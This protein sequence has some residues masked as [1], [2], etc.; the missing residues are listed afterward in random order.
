MTPVKDS[1]PVQQPVSAQQYVSVVSSQ[2]SSFNDAISQRINRAVA[3][4][5]GT[6]C[7][8]RNRTTSYSRLNHVLYCS[9]LVV[10]AYACMLIAIK[11]LNPAVLMAGG[12]TSYMTHKIENMNHRAEN[13]SHRVAEERRQTPPAT[14]RI[15]VID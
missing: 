14:P 15:E 2:S 1:V 7:Y 13:M 10:S 11:V 9:V 5:V 6:Y 4:A 8:N 3:A 12:F